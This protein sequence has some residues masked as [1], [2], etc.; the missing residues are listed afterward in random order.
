MVDFLSRYFKNGGY[1]YQSEY[2]DNYYRIYDDTGTYVTIQDDETFSLDSLKKF[3]LNS[4]TRMKSRCN[5]DY[6]TIQEY[7]ELYRALEPL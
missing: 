3:I 5:S 6:E 2:E 1:N 7:Q 4:I